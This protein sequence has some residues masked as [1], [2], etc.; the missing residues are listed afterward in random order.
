MREEYRVKKK[1]PMNLKHKPA[2]ASEMTSFLFLEP[3]PQLRKVE[4]TKFKV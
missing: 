1:L 3:Q 2:G 4:V